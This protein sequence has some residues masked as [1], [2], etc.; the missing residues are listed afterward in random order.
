SLPAPTEENRDYIQDLANTIEVAESEREH[1]NIWFKKWIVAVVACGIDDAA[2]NQTTLVLVGPQGAGKTSWLLKLVPPRLSKY[3]FTGTI[4]PGNKDSEIQLAE[5]LLINLDELANLGHKNLNSLK[6]IITK[7]FVKIRRPYATYVEQMPRRVSFMGSVNDS[8]FLKDETGNRRFLCFEALS[9]DFRHSINLDLVYA[10]ALGLYNG[11]FRYWFQDEEI[12]EINRHNEKYKSISLEQE[13]LESLFEPCFG[14]TEPEFRFQTGE[15]LNYI[16]TH[17]VI[18]QK[19][20]ARGLGIALK[21]MNWSK[22]KVNGIR[23]WLL[24]RKQVEQGEQLQ[25]A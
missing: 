8:E 1:W 4:N 23:Y 20:S 9:I 7:S 17:S 13:V 16:F 21:R 15:L 10:Q 3:C 24:K 22:K 11:G 5:N 14:S 6:E 19:L 25:A 12:D 2:V 18:G